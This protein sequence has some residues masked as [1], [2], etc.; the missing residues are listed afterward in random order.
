MIKAFAVMFFIQLSSQGCLSDKQLK[1]IGMVPLVKPL[2]VTKPGVCAP[3]YARSKANACVDLVNLKTDFQVKGNAWNNLFIEEQYEIMAN[4]DNIVESYMIANAEI[5]KDNKFNK[6]AVSSGTKKAFEEANRYMDHYD[7]DSSNIKKEVTAC[8][9]SQLT[10]SYGV[11]CLLSS[12]IATKYVIDLKSFL[13]GETSSTELRNELAQGIKVDNGTDDT[14][15]T[16]DA[17]KKTQEETKSDTTKTNVDDNTLDSFNQKIQE[18]KEKYSNKSSRILERKLV[19]RDPQPEDIII[20]NVNEQTADVVVGNCANTIK[21][22]CLYAKM[23]DALNSANKKSAKGSMGMLCSEEQMKCTSKVPDSTGIKKNADGCN[24]KIKALLMQ[25]FI[26]DF[27]QGFVDKDTKAE[28][29]L[30]SHNNPI[31][32]DTLYAKLAKIG[33]GKG[34]TELKEMRDNQNAKKRKL[35]QQKESGVLVF[36]ASDTGY[37]TYDEGAEAGWSRSSGIAFLKVSIMTMLISFL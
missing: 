30:K 35:V 1:S 29:Y 22:V 20:I 33:F 36:K 26:K 14:K 32:R 7:I 34:D 8:K 15:T 37:N 12:D 3:F 6:T 13:E 16:S 18:A 2:K 21:N 11:Y 31:E 25:S 19:N 4:F 28:F 24:H 9:D 17:N 23:Q 5:A 10:N 27:N